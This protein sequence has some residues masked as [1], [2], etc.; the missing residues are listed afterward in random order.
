MRFPS[1]TEAPFSNVNMFGFIRHRP[2][3]HIQ[4]VTNGPFCKLDIIL[5]AID[6]V[7][8]KFERDSF[9]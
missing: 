5:L 9:F 7:A 3:S 6:L 2:A 8:T 4:Q 1:Y